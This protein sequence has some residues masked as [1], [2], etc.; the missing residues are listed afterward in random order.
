MAC[1]LDTDSFLATFTRMTSRRG[2]PLEVISDHG[3]NF[4]GANNELKDFWHC[5]IK[6]E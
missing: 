3:M 6:K 1:S 4:I 2:V 5:W